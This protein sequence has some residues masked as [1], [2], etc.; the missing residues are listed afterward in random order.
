MLKF[1]HDPLRKN[2]RR[3]VCLGLLFFIA[4]GSGWA[5][6]N[7]ATPEALSPSGVEAA[8]PKAFCRAVEAF[9]RPIWHGIP[10]FSF[11]FSSLAQPPGDITQPRVENHSAPRQAVIDVQIYRRA[12]AEIG[13]VLQSPWRH[14]DVRRGPEFTTL[15]LPEADIC[16]TGTGTMPVGADSLAPDGFW[17]RFIPADSPLAPFVLMVQPGTLRLTVDSLLV[18]RAAHA[19]LMS[20]GGWKVHFAGGMTLFFAEHPGGGVTFRLEADQGM[21]KI[22]NFRFF[23]GTLEIPAP[24]WTPE[25]PWARESRQIQAV[26]RSDLEKLIF[27]GVRRLFS[28]K[29]PV[30]SNPLSSTETSHGKIRYQG[31]QLVAFLHGTPEQIGT[32]HGRLLRPWIPRLIDST[33]YL[34]GLVETIGKGRWFLDD[35]EGAWKRL[36]PHIPADHHREL[37][38]LASA[39]P[40]ISLREAR[41]ANVF[42]E[43]FHCSGFAL[44]GRATSDGVLYHGRVLDYMTEIGLQNSAVA[45]VVKPVGKIPFFNPGFAGFLGSVGGMN[46]K[47]VSLGEMGGGGRFLW[48]GVPMSVLMRRALEECD[49]LDQVKRLWQNNP[50]TCEYYYVFADGH[51]RT[52]TAL[53][54]TPTALEFLGPGEAHPQLGEGIADAVVLS[55]G[56]RLTTL[57]EWVKKGHGTFTASSALRLMD[58]PVAMKSNLHN[59][60][61]V[62]EKQ[63]VYVAIATPD[64]PAADQ[65]YQRYDVK[66]LLGE[67]PT[68]KP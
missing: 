23:E 14:V 67:I 44:F 11:H 32:A 48:D 27:R 56:K 29:V 4:T 7:R 51:A 20:N 60:L 61:F 24:N 41:L 21:R 17:G 19:E 30:E 9:L 66:A 43:Y 40:E 49:S 15:N 65:E 42:P 34:V 37:E 46:A 50:R 28:L 5:G 26:D 63:E 8:W 2:F 12:N 25:I 13:L 57:R 3:F 58:R 47:G 68:S 33:I 54:A 62:P 10:A 45:F 64:G 39:C 55:A 31:R 22:E 1:P 16:F 6:S 36:S 52:A 38:A 59:I 35:L 53:K 18:P